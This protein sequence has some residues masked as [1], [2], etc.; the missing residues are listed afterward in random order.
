MARRREPGRKGI[1]TATLDDAEGR[2]PIEA[3]LVSREPPPPSTAVK[4]AAATA[5][6]L[7]EQSP[8]LT[9]VQS[10]EPTASPLGK[11]LTTSREKLEL[12]RLAA[13]VPGALGVSVKA[14]SSLSSL[15]FGIGRPDTPPDWIALNESTSPM[16]YTE[17]SIV[18]MDALKRRSTG[19]AIIARGQCPGVGAGLLQ[20]RLCRCFPEK[21]LPGFVIPMQKVAWP[22]KGAHLPVALGKE[23]KGFAEYLRSGSRLCRPRNR[24]VFRRF[25]QPRDT[26]R[27]E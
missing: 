19:T 7:E 24:D 8:Q 27:L 11:F 5:A 13:H 18:P 22:E 1:H 17:F 4:A 15:Q 9:V 10:V 2:L 23:G 25:G 26:A 12:E 21:A 6:V 14:A 20:W 16:S 3:D